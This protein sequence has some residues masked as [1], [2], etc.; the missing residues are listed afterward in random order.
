MPGP[1]VAAIVLAA[2]GSV[3]FG[4]PK[5]LLLWEGRPLV[6]HSADTA[7]A[8]GLDPIIVV[9]GAVAQQVAA[10]LKGR[11][12]QVLQN[13][14]WQEGMSSS[15]SVG[16]A[17][18]PDETQAA[19]FMQIDQPL[20]TPQFLHT[21]IARWQ[22]T[23]ADIVVPTWEGKHG[24]PVLFGRAL[25][26]ELAQLSGDM[27][28]R[29]LFNRY[30]QRMTT[31]PVTDPSSLTDADTPEA[32]AQLQARAQQSHPE[33][34][35]KS[36]RAI[37]CDMDGVLW[38]GNTPLPG[39]HDFFDLLQRRGLHYMLVTNNASRTPA[40]YVEKLAGMGVSTD[41]SHV[42][43][44]AMATADYLA[45]I[46]GT[47]AL[48]YVVGAPGLHEALQSRGFRLSD[49][50]TADYVVAGWTQAM[51]WETLATATRLIRNG[52]G[53]IGTNPDRTYPAEDHLVPGAGAQLAF[54]EAATD[55]H[56][57]VV[58]K[59]EPILYQQA[60]AH[61]GVRSQETLVIGDRLNTDIVGGVR[62]G[63]P[64]ALMLSGIQKREDLPAS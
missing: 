7:W 38:R 53:F 41:T 21:L 48:V 44:S 62:L 31:L 23:S 49:G 32:Y 19:I 4:Q 26:P 51:T 5:Q 29:A 27:G 47:D 34:L 60:L 17:A 3:R 56:P 24:A 28:G 46:A 20:V 14:R 2:G 40:Q 58:G 10:A 18:L 52:A 64:T 36:I 45:E 30:P 43:N 42:L 50:D 25:F 1:N 16:L 57:L 33:A 13:Y 12:V 8:A 37:I 22:E 59:P 39:L 9:T 55:V 63:L 6:A 11:P 35:L 15:V 61:M 54:L